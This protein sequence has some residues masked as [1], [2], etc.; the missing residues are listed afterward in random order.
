M[1]PCLQIGAI[2]L[3]PIRLGFKAEVRTE[4]ML[5]L[6]VK[7]RVRVGVKVRVRGLAGMVGVRVRNKVIHHVHHESPYKV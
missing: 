5:E 2:F 7:V 3:G 1:G 6:G 4:F